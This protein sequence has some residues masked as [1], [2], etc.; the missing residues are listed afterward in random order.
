MVVF[1]VG[2]G[3]SRVMLGDSLLLPV[4]RIETRDWKYNFT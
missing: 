3:G 1:V 4:Q 2:E